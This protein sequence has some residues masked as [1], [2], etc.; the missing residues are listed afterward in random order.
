MPSA[1]TVE[2]STTPP[3]STTLSEPGGDYNR[4]PY[5]SNPYP[6]S[7][8]ARLFALARLFGLSTPDLA[9]A[10]V[11]E[12]GC[13]SGGNIIPLA[14]RF[15]QAR[16]LGVDLTPR[17][18]ADG[19]AR[20]K[21]L[22][23]TN[24]DIVQGDVITFD[25]GPEP[26][27][28][29]I[30]HGVYS[31]VPDAAKAAIL[32]LTGTHLAPNGVGYISYN[33]LPGWR[34]RGIIRD[35]MLFHAGS[36]GAPELRIAKARWVLEN[37]AKV[38]NT[39][40]SYG[41]RLQEEAKALSSFSDAY[42]LGEFLAPYNDPCYFRDFMIAADQAGL[43]FL[44]ES[45]IETCLPE[46]HGPEVAKLIRTMSA[47]QLMPMEQYIDFLVGRQFRQ[48]LLVRKER[49]AQIQR[50]LEPQR[51]AGLSVSGKLEFAPDLSADGK[52]VFRTPQGRTVTTTSA[53]VRQ[54][55]D[56]LA[57]A[58]PE[59][60]TAEELAAEV[61]A[62]GTALTEEDRRNILD[63]VFKMII[64]GLVKVSSVPIRLG[65]GDA[66]RPVAFALARADAAARRTTTTNLR[67]ER[68]PIDAVNLY[69]LPLLDGTKDRPQLVHELIRA[70][71]SGFL[72]ITDQ[73]TGV[74]LKG[75]AMA[76]AVSEHVDQAIRRLAE[77]ALL[78]PADGPEG[79][80]PQA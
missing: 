37:L 15:P 73:R 6:Q 63:M 47:N 77:A 39:G 13:A 1:A 68:C 34:Q 12:L 75:E 69:L 61:A 66:E 51:A 64:G 25:P 62:D 58:W 26:F 14:V 74:Q 22:G 67:H 56:R 48:S 53:T 45:D 46:T 59:T 31:W 7:E 78:L 5:I 49:T 32:R 2:S 30:S 38:V 40:H 24:I 71:E 18:V 21:E 27:D 54:A 57:A 76:K 17:H 9:T 20:I 28:A 23:L 29:I 80:S 10:R 19:K 43:V 65:R 33:V 16:F 50:H 79:Q 42:I 60:R 11:L 55:I 72:T 52:F 4:I 8:P 35:L 44:C 70:I 41:V 3:L 36:D